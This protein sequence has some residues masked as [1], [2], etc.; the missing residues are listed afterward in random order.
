[1]DTFSLPSGLA[2]TEGRNHETGPAVKNELDLISGSVLATSHSQLGLKGPSVLSSA[3]GF[4]PMVAHTCLPCGWEVEA[5]EA[6]ASRQP[7]L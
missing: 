2:P 4:D 5:E 3:G 6:R 1:M 7:V